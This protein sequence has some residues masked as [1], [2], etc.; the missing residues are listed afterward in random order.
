VLLCWVREAIEQ[1]YG[2]ITEVETERDTRAL[3]M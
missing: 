1:K 2:A 3:L